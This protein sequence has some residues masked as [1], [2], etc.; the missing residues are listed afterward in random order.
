MGLCMRMR[1]CMRMCMRTCMRIRMC[2]HCVC[3]YN[4]ANS[5]WKQGY[6]EEWSEE[7]EVENLW[8][9]LKSKLSDLRNLFVPKQL[10]SAEPSWKDKGSFPIDKRTR[11][12][13]KSKTTT[14]RAWMSA[15]TRG[16]VGIARLEYTKARNKAKRM[17]RHSKKLF[18]QEIALQAKNN[19][20][21]FWSHTRRKLK[22]KCGVAPLLT[23]SNDKNSLKF[24]DQDKANI[25]QNQFSSVFT[26]EPE[27]EIPR[28]ASRTDSRISNLYVTEEMV[29]NQL[30]KL[31]VNKSC[32]PDEI[33]PRM[34]IEL[35]DYIAEPVALLFNLTIKYGIIP[36]DWKWAYLSPIYKKGA[37]SNAE[38]Y[39]PISLTSILCKIMESFARE[40]LMHHLLEK[41]LLSTKQFGFITGRSTTVQLLSYLDKC[42]KTIVDG[43]VVDAIYLDFAKAFDTVPHRRLIGK[44]HAYGIKGNISNWIIEFLRDRTQVVRVNGTQSVPAPVVSGIPQGTVLGPVLFVLYINDIL[45]SVTSE[46]FLFADD[47]KI[48]HHITSIEDAF[49]LQS[50]IESLEDWSNKWLLHFHP[51]KCH[52][53]TLG[54]FEN[55]MY[56]KRYKICNKEIEHVFSEKDLR[57][58]IDSELLFEE[59]ISNKVRV[60]N[61]IVGLI[62]RSF[63]HLDCKSCTKIYTAFVRPHLEYAQ[64][65]WAPHF[66]KHINMLENVQIRASKLVDGLG[67][68]DYPERLKR[69]N[70]PTL[71]YRRLRG[72]MIEIYKHF[73]TYDK[74]IISKSFQPRERSTRKHDFQILNR[75]PKDGIRGIQSNSFYYRSPNIWNDLPRAVVNAKHVNS[76]KNQLDE[77]WKDT[78]IKFDHTFTTR[79]DS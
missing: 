4:L 1:M 20:K 32:G 44:L 66:R 53:L 54:K 31:N 27:G 76:F 60:A 61:A 5:K 39:R 41:K 71:A 40:R 52:V 16:D 69:L 50:D 49:K 46:G 65:V 30:T 63:T 36:E 37:R 78:P 6:M 10:T 14:F 2:M 47:T 25:L 21:A 24:N 29:L 45:D 13:I 9:S 22:T 70:L 38:N 35:A 48:F 26:H 67:N 28:I 73:H 62:R 74:D 51:D 7:T 68:V 3:V 42:V 55:I 8:F 72:D 77:F 33:H 23:N 79:S 12:A 64:S 17:L 34:L 57:V 75:K 59:H 11:E 19:P 18:E 56:T 58:I 43:G 15:K